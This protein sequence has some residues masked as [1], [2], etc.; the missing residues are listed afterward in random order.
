[1]I[2]FDN[3]LISHFLSGWDWHRAT[4][5]HSSI[6]WASLRPRNSLNSKVFLALGCSV[7]DEVRVGVVW[8]TMIVSVSLRSESSCTYAFTEY[9]IS[10]FQFFSDLQLNVPEWIQ[11]RDKKGEIKWLTVHFWSCWY[12]VQSS[13]FKPLALKNFVLTKQS[14][15]WPVSTY[16]WRIYFSIVLF[17]QAKQTK[18]FLQIIFL[19]TVWVNS[20][21]FSFFLITTNEFLK[22]LPGTTYYIIVEE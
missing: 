8:L 16:Q 19:W 12:T 13:L 22:L 5:Q 3:K 14:L 2:S 1:M 21:S 18:Y 7:W 9:A 11:R 6:T 4:H 17:R 20:I 15:N 10:R